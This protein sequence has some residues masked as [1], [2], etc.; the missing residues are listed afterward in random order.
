MGITPD[1]NGMMMW[2]KIIALLA[3]SRNRYLYVYTEI[4]FEVCLLKIL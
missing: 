1:Q 3:S 2:E 4:D